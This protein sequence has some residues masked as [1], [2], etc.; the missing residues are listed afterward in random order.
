[1][2]WDAV[3]HA[4]LYTI[5]MSD[6]PEDWQKKKLLNITDTRYEYPFDHSVEETVYAY[7][8]VEAT[9]EDGSTVEVT[10]AHKVQV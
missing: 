6:T 10:S 8:W 4:T 9:C 2:V 7:F 3:P 5:Y 1:M